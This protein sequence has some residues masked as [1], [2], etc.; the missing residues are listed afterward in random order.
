MAKHRIAVLF[1]GK[2]KD[3]SVSLKSA[4]CVLSS[5]SKTKY[6]VIPLGITKS[7]RWLYYPGSFDAIPDGTWETDADCCPA[8]LSPDPVQHGIIK[9]LGDGG[10]SLQR[11]D[12]IIS[13]LHG[14]FGEGGRIQSLCKLSQIPFVGSG[15]EASSSGLDKI[16]THMLLDRAGIDT[17]PYHSFERDDIQKIDSAI[18]NMESHLPYP[19]YV[20]AA[21]CSSS[22][23]ASVAF[24]RTEL[25][26]ALKIAF[27]HHHKALVEKAVVG[28]D[29]S[30]IVYEDEQK[31]QV[32]VI[33]EIV[34]GNNI[35]EKGKNYVLK[36][37]A[38]AFPADLT[39]EQN[40]YIRTAAIRAFRIL[41]CSGF[42]RVD[43]T[44]QEKTIFCSKIAAMPGFSR[45]G[46]LSQLMFASGFEYEQML[47]MLIVNAFDCR[48]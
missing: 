9:F 32:S 14:K 24:N 16:L 43:F 23:G 13:V 47:D 48:G 10:F 25:I 8:V 35:F 33:G 7:G 39:N 31:A 36:T 2:S 42:A 15:P 40:E 29:V 12:V 5:L 1:G 11:I 37:G 27:S 19:V 22:I 28:R 21:S 38:L 3:H 30:C 18:E 45:E 46:I 44:V 26:S 4:H 17:I 6:E 20:K 34:S 41:G